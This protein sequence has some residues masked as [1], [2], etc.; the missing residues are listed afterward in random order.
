MKRLLLALV[1]VA[2]AIVALGFYQGWFH[3]GSDETD[4]KS[5]VT[6]SVDTEKF[7]QDSKTAV[8]K[9]KDLGHQNKDKAATRSEKIMDGTLVSVSSD[10]LT[11]ADKVEKEHRYALATHVTV[12]CDGKQCKALD[13]KAGMR[14]RVTSENADADTATQIEALD[15]NPDFEKGA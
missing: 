6:V 15:K 1:F 12:T 10:K 2:A 14:I 7:Q 13:L 5:N 3:V 4:G 9:V 11:M 8:A